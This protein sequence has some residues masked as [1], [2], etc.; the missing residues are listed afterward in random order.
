M[1]L[2]ASK[3]S[4]CHHQ[5]NSTRR[6]S[7]MTISWHC[8]HAP[9]PLAFHLCTLS[10][11]TICVTSLLQNL[12]PSPQGSFHYGLNTAQ[13]FTSSFINLIMSF[14]SSRSTIFSSTSWIFTF[15]NALLIKNRLYI[16]L[17]DYIQD[18]VWPWMTLKSKRQLSTSS[19]IVRSLWV[20]ITYR[21][22]SI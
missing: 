14:Q 3:R 18:A 12:T 11:G 1:S 2:S 8:S 21:W 10:F 4:K 6:R 22:S 13:L 17:H 9:N 7:V 20:T 19:F 16:N 5:T 15:S